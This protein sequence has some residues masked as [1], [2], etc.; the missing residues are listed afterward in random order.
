VASRKEAT[1]IPKQQPYFY[2]L[3]RRWKTMKHQFA[4][5]IMLLISMG[6][7]GVSVFSDQDGREKRGSKVTKEQF[8]R[9]EKVLAAHEARLLSLPGVV[10]VG[11]GMTKKGDQPAIH[12][13]L[14]VK[15]AGG[16]SPTAIPKQIDKV[17]VRVIETDEIKAR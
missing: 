12:V 15:A 8:R 9:A 5:G 11:I 13:Y 6:P 14:N 1:D 7:S 2:S 4:V 17:P 16:E 3:R 10:G